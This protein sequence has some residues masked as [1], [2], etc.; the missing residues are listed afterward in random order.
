MRFAKK[1][2][3]PAIDIEGALVSL[4]WTGAELARRIGVSPGRVSAWR[5]GKSK[6]GIPG[7]VAAYLSL[8]LKAR[9]LLV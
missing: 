9:E 1:W 5:R 7:P 6:R 8:A 2:G 4:D 3:V